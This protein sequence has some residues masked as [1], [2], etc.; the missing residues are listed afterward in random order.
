MSQ[1]FERQ[2]SD[3]I[4][5]IH[6]YTPQNRKTLSPKAFVLHKTKSLGASKQRAWAVHLLQ[7]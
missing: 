2:S 7:R 1:L 4:Y 6:K 5:K 3:F